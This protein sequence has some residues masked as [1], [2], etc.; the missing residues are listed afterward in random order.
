MALLHAVTPWVRTALADHEIV[1]DARATLDC[2]VIPAS[3][4]ADFRARAIGIPL[5][6]VGG[7]DLATLT[8]AL[9]DGNVFGHIPD[10]DPAALRVAVARAL[11]A[12]TQ[13]ERRILDERRRMA[14]MVETMADG[15][16]MTDERSEVFLINPSARRLLGVEPGVP[17]TAKYLKEKLG[18]YPFDLVAR[19]HSARE[20]LKVGEKTLHSIISP[21]PDGGVVV[22]LRDITEWKELE[23]RKEEFVSIVSH[24]L[25]T[26]LTSIAGA[27]DIV[28][29]S[30]VGGLSDKQRLYLSLA[31]DSCGKLHVIVND[32][33]DVAR[34]EQG[35]MSMRFSPLALDQVVED[36]VDRFRAAAEAKSISMSYRQSGQVRIVGDGDRLAQVLSN[37]LSNALKFTPDSGRIEVEV[38]GPGFASSH[39]GVSLW[40]NGEAIPESDRERVF[41]KFEQVAAST[42]RRVGG[43]GLG[44]AISR[45]IVEGH[46]GKIW[47]ENAPVGT[48]FVFTL[49]AAPIESLVPPEPAAETPQPS[50][51]VLI[52][53]DDLAAAYLLKGVLMAAGH[54]VQVCEDVDDALVW[55]RE[56][57]PELVVV[58][59]GLDG[60]DATAVVEIL[61]HDP[62]TRKAAVVAVGERSALLHGADAVFPKPVNVDLFRDTVR[63]LLRDRAGDASVKI[64]VVDD[65]V[66]I[67]MVCREVL[68]KAGYAVREA[69]DG[70]AALSEAKR[71]RPDLMLLDVM[72]PDLDGFATARAFR[73]DPDGQMTPVIFVSARGQTADKVRAFKLGAED[74]LVKPFDSLELLA[75]VEKALARR[76]R[77]L[78]ASPTTMLPGANTIEAEIERRLAEGGDFAFGYVD[79]DNL[80]AFNDYY[81]IARADGVIRQLGDLLREVITRE[82]G[83]GDFLGH[84]AGDDFVFITTAERVDAIGRRIC[85]TFDRLVPLYYSKADRQRGYIETW[86]RYGALRQF[87]IM[88]VSVAALTTATGRFRTYAE[89]SAA[90]AEAKQ[91]AKAIEGSSYVRD[92]WVILGKEAA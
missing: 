46:G 78:G 68:E 44:L 77:E 58:D 35:K 87:R 10:E 4:L 65:D 57:G 33:L 49:P 53:A 62:E 9:G 25:R 56:R 80:K 17:V 71:F 45:A 26:P 89:L 90:A 31:R 39:V 70:R 67:R 60:A 41:D 82:G 14:L 50:V 66:G 92:S 69:V 74:Y 21:M 11:A 84:I 38:F 42:T 75:R 32:L 16:I 27:L 3:E 30:Y 12:R 20:E 59:L 81:G 52:V 40:N 47:V 91:R 85:Q 5:V 15:V 48:K 76:E 83:P 55:A 6:L 36:C 43:T 63:R 7:A 2:A 23:Q 61:K 13:A 86:D 37:L 24:E 1:A 54:R 8:A 29:Q 34:F 72:M 73:A 88:S 19:S 51:Q 18:F 22:V 28:L 64:L 79:L